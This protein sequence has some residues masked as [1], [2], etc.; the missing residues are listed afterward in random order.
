M[1]KNHKKNYEIKKKY[2][3]LNKICS[4]NNNQFLIIN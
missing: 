1:N 2:Y 3:D 4:L